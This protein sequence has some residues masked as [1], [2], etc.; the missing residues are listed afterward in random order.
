[1]AKTLRELT[2][3]VALLL[4][5]TP[6]LSAAE[7]VAPG[8]P[9]VEAEQELQAGHSL[10]GEAF[11]EGARQAA[12]PMAG[13]GPIRFAVTSDNPDV[14]K[15]VEQG[16]G[17]LHGF[18]YFEAERSFRQ[19]A[20]L[21]PDCAICYW[22]MAMANSGNS[23]RAKKFLEEAIARRGH[24]TEREA[25][26]IDA[27]EDS[28]N[29]KGSAK[30]KAIRQV[31]AFEEIAA[32]YPEDLEA[33]AWLGYTLYKNRSNAGKSYEDVDAALKEVLAIEPLHPVHHY[34]IH[35]WDSKD[36][37]NALDSSAKSGEGT[38]A[39]AHMWHMPG[40]IYSRLKRYEDAAW[41]QE[42][43]ARTDHAHMMRD[44][45]LPDEIHNFAHN[46]EW[47]I[48]DLVFV[49]RWQDGLDLAKNM[50]ELPRH[51]SHNTISRRRSSYYGRV[52]LFEVLKKYELWSDLI[53]YT[54]SPYLEPTDTDTEQVRRLEHRG[55]AFAHLHHVDK[56][57]ETVADLQAR[58]D[59]V[60]AK[61]A[62]DLRKHEEAVAKAKKEGKKPPVQKK[63]IGAD[64]VKSLED[65]IALI[66]GRL[67]AEYGDFKAAFTMLKKA[68]DDKSYLARLQFQAG[69][70]E[71]A[72]KLIADEVKSRENQVLPLAVQIDLLWQAGKKKE[73]K[74]AFVALQK[75]SGSLQ[76]GVEVF[77][78]LTP[79]AAELGLT[80]ADGD[81]RI[82][83]TPADDFGKRPELDA[84]GP[85]RWSPSP[86][87]SWKLRDHTGKEVSLA[88][89]QG[90]PVVLIFYLGYSCLHCVEQLHAFAPLAEKY[91]QA[92]ISLLAIS[93]E[94]VEEL[95]TSLDDYEG[96]MP[97]PLLANSELDIFKAYRVYDDFEQVPLHGTFLI[98]GEGMIRWQDIGFEPFKD[99]KFLLEESVRLLHQSTQPLP[100]RLTVV[101]LPERPR[102]APV[103]VKIDDLPRIDP[104]GVGGSLVVAGSQLSD[105][106]VDRF[107]QLAQGENNAPGQAILLALDRS[108]ATRAATRKLLDRWNEGQ[109]GEI[110]VVRLDNAKKLAAQTWPALLQQ[111]TGVWIAGNDAAQLKALASIKS[112]QQALARFVSQGKV[113]GAAGEAGEFLASLAF[114][115]ADS[116]ALA[117]STLALLPDAIVDTHAVGKESPSRL[118]AALERQPYAIGLELDAAAALV[119]NGRLLTKVGEGD[120]RIKR[121]G[122]DNAAAAE[123]VLATSEDQ[124]DF[125]SLRRAARD[126]VTGNRPPQQPRPVQVDKGTLIIIGG[127]GMPKDIISRFVE[128]AG[129]K[130]ANIVVLP[131]ALADPIPAR[132]SISEAFRKAGAANVTVLPGRTL[133]KVQSDEY[134]TALKNA[135]GLWFGG[136]RQW[137]FVDAYLDTP[138]EKL[139]HDVLKRGGVI[140]GS[141]AGASIQ[142]EYLARGNPLGNLDVMADGYERGLGFLPGAAVDQHFSQRKRQ[143]DM[144]SLVTRYPQLLGI[145]IDESTALIVQ[146]EVGEVAGSG[147]V[148]FYDTAKKADGELQPD[149]VTDGQFYSLTARKA[150][151]APV[152]QAAEAAFDS[153][154]EPVRN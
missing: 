90:K 132:D 30:E 74:D 96:G 126:I 79:I 103:V 9:A 118:D 129:G 34:R 63:A 26:Y 1:M 145:G 136:G 14:Q 148:Y 80:S 119:I 28:L 87:P 8:G 75:L 124:A 54:D 149:K 100:S 117:E 48:R 69:E 17:Q 76:L 146:G 60:K 89:Y 114:V 39:I 137:R 82:A 121:R 12:Y 61:A 125:V 73:A 11:N 105:A 21:D 33:K 68:D 4:L 120:V 110:R 152:K 40:H 104:V 97:I 70:K 16:I 138:A 107:L 19:A 154:P 38:P 43:S 130:K 53:A 88:Q 64:P 29:G 56:V 142:A 101:D 5:I 42:A 135:T 92:G 85:F 150:I 65:S 47:L 37:K 41:Q 91:Q 31:A 98:D 113:V 7:S 151:D 59:K 127:G 112:A 71:E 134:Q 95:K 50:I 32:R 2:R 115:D 10:H 131:T 58:L 147:G 67:L 99:P 122:D 144:V 72:L 20:M 62:A 35:L 94:N 133:E 86:A 52:R 83:R 128:L 66:E 139:M 25:M 140:M 18:W 27:L 109:L 106:A 24:A 3:F 15:F 108:D 44:R 153:P 84:L 6:A 22:G 111:A 123:I 57:K 51:P 23:S 141:S 55:I 102:P 36:A 46:N 143:P 93:C 81:W 77:D 78:R 45:V 49:G 13:T 116:S